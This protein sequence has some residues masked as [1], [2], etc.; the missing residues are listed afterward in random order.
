MNIDDEAV[1]H[2]LSESNAVLG[3]FLSFLLQEAIKGDA[4]VRL[5]ALD[6]AAE[7]RSMLT[8]NGADEA[9]LSLVDTIVGSVLALRGRTH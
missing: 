3:A 2:R 4:S 8:A 7:L 5:R 1:S 9:S 6:C